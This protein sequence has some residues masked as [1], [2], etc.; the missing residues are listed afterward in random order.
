[1]FHTINHTI[2]NCLNSATAS[3]CQARQAHAHILK[4]GLFNDTH[5]TTRLLSLYANNLCFTDA[6]LVLDSVCDAN[7]LSFST[8]IHAFSK[9]KHFEHVLRVFS[10]MVSRGL[11]PDC[12]VLPSAVK[13]CAGLQA[14]KVG[15]QVHG[16]AC[17]TEA[18][19][20]S[21]VKSSLIH[22]YLKCN[23]I[24]DA[25]KLFDAMPEKDVIIWSALI[26]GYSRQGR[27]DKAKEL[28]SDMRDMGVEPNLV[29]WNGM[30]AGFSQSSLYCEAVMLFQ[31]MYSEG[32][33]PDGST[34]CSVLPA[35]GQLEDLISGKQI[36][37]FA[38]KQ[39]FG[40]DKC[41][42]SALIDMYG[43]CTCTL[44]MSR[45]FDEADQMDIG[46]CNAFITGL[47]RN[48]LVD[49]ALEIFRQFEDSRI[50]LNV[51]SWTS[52]ISSCSQNGKD[53]EALELFRE[54][55][56][57]GVE[58]NCITIPCLLPACGNIAALVHGK[59]VHCF[60]I[61]RGISGDVY[62]ACSQNGLTE[63]GLHYFNCMS[64][65][66]GIEARMEHYA[67]MVT[68]LGRVGKL[69]EAYSMIE[70]MPFEPDA[71]VWGALLSSCRIHHNVSLGKV[72]AEKLFKLEP[73]NPGNYILL[74]NT[75]ASKAM[76]S[77]VN[78]VRDMM[79]NMGL[80]KNP[81]CSWIGISN[82]LHM[83]LSGD[84]SHP[85]MDQILE[86]LDKL[87][88]EMKKSGYFPI[89]NFVL[90]DVEEQDKEQM[91]CGHSEKLAV[92]LG[93]LNTRSGAPLQ[94]IK[95]LRICGDCHAFI[96]FIS[97]FEGREL[98]VR[99]TNRF[100]HFKDGVCSCGDYW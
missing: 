94:V 19:S 26:S 73:G 11:V 64:K 70:K 36:H 54:M 98:S 68:L 78:I 80:R 86:K 97:S 81:G 21:F 74:S 34:V 12:Y 37:G 46:S 56:S 6:N 22:M 100:H 39:G 4:V 31:K 33:Q 42:V 51:V 50:E 95:N 48:G 75:Y 79:K 1:M 62:V 10:Q 76:W 35:L 17:V 43:K 14:L 88:I 40:L 45:V 23:K 49:T 67:C 96:K 90:Q 57:N 66:H 29:L 27:L 7:L 71:C 38:I 44:D 61:R 53:M 89:T 85:Q 91:L 8:L 87:G 83:L 25:H 41:V 5:L 93:L 9:F 32:F 15:K 2:V 30:I 65:D 72:A 28:F 99:D 60:S 55:Q 92:V 24:K 58:P 63:V 69:Q 18:E 13:A 59:A 20:D 84:K 3:L 82:K 16:I 47:S 77:E 52:M